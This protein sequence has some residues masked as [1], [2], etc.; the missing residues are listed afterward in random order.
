MNRSVRIKILDND[1]VH[2]TEYKI[3]KYQEIVTAA[4]EFDHMPEALTHA[5]DYLH[6][7]ENT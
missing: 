5:K 1:M 6:L 3:V 7:T 4:Y 2:V